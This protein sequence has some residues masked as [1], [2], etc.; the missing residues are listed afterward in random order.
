M[1]LNKTPKGRQSLSLRGG[2][3]ICD[4]QSLTAGRHSLT[5]RRKWK[6]ITIAQY[7]I[8][9]CYL[10]RMEKKMETTRGWGWG[11]GWSKFEA[12]GARMSRGGGIKA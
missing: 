1:T 5:G 3:S 10:G 4:S 6:L 11:G 8:Y 7:C 2:A 9:R 12:G